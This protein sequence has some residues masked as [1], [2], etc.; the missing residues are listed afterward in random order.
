MKSGEF[1]LEWVAEDIQYPQAEVF[2]VNW[3][4]T[5][6]EHSSHFQQVSVSSSFF[7]TKFATDLC[8]KR[9]GEQGSR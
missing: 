5:Y 3:L 1:W 6:S 8:G 2:E 4:S 7:E 9:K